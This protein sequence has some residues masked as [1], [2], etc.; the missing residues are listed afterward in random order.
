VAEGLVRAADRGVCGTVNLG[1]GVGR[2]LRSVIA[3]VGAVLDVN[4][5]VSIV[6]AGPE[7]PAATLAE[8]S[9][10]RRWLGFVPRTDLPQLVH[11]QALAAGL[12]VADVA[13]QTTSPRATSSVVPGRLPPSARPLATVELESRRA[14]R[15]ALAPAGDPRFMPTARQ[16]KVVER[17]GSGEEQWR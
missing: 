16:L 7:E 10:C 17:S 1:T 8:T 14:R 11:R 2:S 15:A 3:A 6:S 13:P 5:T 12:P 9:R 4:P